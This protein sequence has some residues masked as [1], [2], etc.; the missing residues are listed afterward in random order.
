MTS[1]SSE[2]TTNSGDRDRD[3]GDDGGRSAAGDDEDDGRRNSSSRNDGTTRERRHSQLQS[4]QQSQSR[5]GSRY[6]AVLVGYGSVGRKQ[7]APAILLHSKKNK[8]ELAAIVDPRLCGHD[9]DDVVGA[10]SSSSSSVPSRVLVRIGGNDDGYSNDDSDDDISIS[11]AAISAAIVPAFSNLLDAVRAVASSEAEAATAETTTTTTTSEIAVIIACPPDDA[12]RIALEA[13]SLAATEAEEE[14][15]GYDDNSRRHRGNA[16]SSASASVAGVMM[17]KPPG[18][19]PDGLIR[20][21]CMAASASASASSADT[22]E[23]ADT[24]AT[25]FEEEEDRLSSSSPY[26]SRRSFSR[27]RK[28]PTLY[29]AYHS[30]ACPCMS[31]AQR[32]VRSHLADSAALDIRITW[33][34]SLHR[35]HPNCRW[36]RRSRFGVLDILFNPFSVLEELFRRADTK[37]RQGNDEEELEPWWF[38]RLELARPPSSSWICVP[39]DWSGPISGSVELAVTAAPAADAAK[40]CSN[41]GPRIAIRADFAWDLP[42]DEPDIWTLSITACRSDDEG[43]GG[44][45]APRTSGSSSTM[46][47]RHGG[48]RMYVDGVLVAPS[49]EDNGND[50]SSN[51]TDIDILRPEYEALY[52]RFAS[53]LDRQRSQVDGV[54]TLRIFDRILVDCPRKKWIAPPD[55][56]ASSGV[57]GG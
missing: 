13:L 14:E 22:A 21:K 10:S 38:E 5:Q 1:W 29:T 33:K 26:R 54:A 57:S 52:R 42:Q 18:Y 50:H 41:A 47:L 8:F 2:T 49:S 32:W 6:K 44:S 56:P 35:W 46:E 16:G 19:D 40:K 43:G 48:A 55:S 11:S 31:A 7:H 25:N 51:D 20:L 4:R 15:Y 12:Q 17:E 3:D 53:L 37:A 28:L 30:T 23:R 27:R 24:S 9:D 45:S 36:I 39:D 34:E